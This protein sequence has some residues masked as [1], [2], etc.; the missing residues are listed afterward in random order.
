VVPSARVQCVAPVTTKRAA[1]MVVLQEE[2]RTS[3]VD[4]LK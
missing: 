4:D 2:L 1:V 3:M